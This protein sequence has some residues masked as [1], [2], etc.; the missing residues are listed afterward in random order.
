MMYMKFIREALIGEVRKAA[1]SLSPDAV[2]KIEYPAETSFGDYSTPIALELGKKLKKNPREVAEEII[3]HGKWPESIAKVEIAGAGFLNFYFSPEFL[4]S[5]LQTV[6]D[7]DEKF[8]TSVYKKGKTVLTD[9]SH[10][11]VAKPM[12]VHHLLSTVI[13][14]AVNKMLAAVG[15]TVIRDNYLGDWGTQFGKLI[16]AYKEWGDQEVVKKDPI[17]QLLKLYVKFHELAEKDPTLEDAARA[18]FKKLEDGDGE[19]KKLWKWVVNLSLAEFQ[20]IWQRLSVEFDYIHGESFYEDKMQEIIDIGI[21]KKIF[22]KGQRGALIAPFSHTK[23]PPAIIL[24]SDG[25][26]LYATRDLA[27][28]NYWEKTWHPDLMLNV[29]DMAQSMYWMQL[30]EVT[31][32]LKLTPAKNVHVSFGRMRFPEKRMSTRKGDIILME[33]LLDEAEEGAYEIVKQKNPEL[34]EDKKREV[35]RQVG[36]GAVKYAILAQNRN[37]DIVFSWDKMLSLEGNSA[38]YIQ[39]VYAR[40]K[41]ILRKGRGER[42]EGRG[43]ENEYIL[44]EPQELA[45]ARLLPKFPEVVFTAA[46]EF[47]PNL[48]TNYLFEL[49]SAFNGFYAVVP[50]LQ[51][52]KDVRAVR[53]QLVSAVAITLKNGLNLLGIQAPEEM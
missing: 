31:D 33:E 35:A 49:A 32:L 1:P 29:V 2:I 46:E 28:I 34:A 8:G 5:F 36:I 10:P 45:V 40:A 19:N 20:K 51:A 14:N 4:T 21:K 22:V 9:I 16:Y 6:H 48:L 24:K 17:T 44:N 42:V 12:G 41:S 39:Y 23:Y 26:T 30:F 50:V 52:D 53:L 25:A 3:T 43:S 47:K 15:Y 13:G 38:P 27:R 18:E 11:N 37:T 7:E